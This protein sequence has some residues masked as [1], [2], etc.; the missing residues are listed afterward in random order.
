ML[1]CGGFDG[2]MFYAGEGRLT[3]NIFQLRTG[4]HNNLSSCLDVA[5]SIF[6]L[7]CNKSEYFRG[8]HSF[9]HLVRLEESFIPFFFFSRVFLQNV[10]NKVKSPQ[11]L[12]KNKGGKRGGTSSVF[13]LAR[14]H[15]MSEFAQD[16][17]VYIFSCGFDF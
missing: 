11:H 1:L 4:L 5:L 2:R 6:I 12:F 7:Y 17:Q 9:S 14:R 13:H 10:Y 8:L 15:L 16:W 3:I